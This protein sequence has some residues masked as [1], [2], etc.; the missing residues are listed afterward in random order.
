VQDSTENNM[1]LDERVKTLYSFVDT[2]G[3]TEGFKRRRLHFV[4]TVM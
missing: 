3:H 2:T 1:Q 4:K